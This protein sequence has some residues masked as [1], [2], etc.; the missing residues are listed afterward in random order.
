VTPLF[1]FAVHPHLD[2]EWPF[3]RERLVTRL[4]EL[5]KVQ[6]VEAASDEP[7]HRK[8]DLADVWGLSWFG[9][10]FTPDCVAAAPREGVLLRV[11]P[12]PLLRGE[13]RPAAFQ[14][15]LGG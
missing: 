4:G 14:A 6:V 8:A 3:V 9:G 12:V 13:L 7:L 10:A 1:L 11:C 5:G 2:R 15:L